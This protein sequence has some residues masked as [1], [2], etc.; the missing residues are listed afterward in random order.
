MYLEPPSYDSSVALD[1]II[2]FNCYSYL[3]KN[4]LLNTLTK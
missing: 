1:K 3:I 2:V 4:K